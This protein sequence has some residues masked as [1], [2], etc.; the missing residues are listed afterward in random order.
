MKASIEARVKNLEIVLGACV[1]LE[2]TRRLIRRFAETREAVNS[3]NA[4]DREI[5]IRDLK[6]NEPTN[7]TFNIL[8]D[9]MLQLWDSR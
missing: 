1:K 5:F 8:V 9:T 6:W 2:S 7:P 4:P 3:V